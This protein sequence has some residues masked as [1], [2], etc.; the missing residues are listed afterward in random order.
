MLGFTS[1][2]GSLMQIYAPFVLTI[3]SFIVSGKL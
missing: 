2:F 1:V 3:L